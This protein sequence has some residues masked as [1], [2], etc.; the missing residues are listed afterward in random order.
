MSQ[1][2]GGVLPYG[3][4]GCVEIHHP[5]LHE[6]RGWYGQTGSLWE[7]E[8]PE[9]EQLEE[10][11]VEQDVSVVKLHTQDPIAFSSVELNNKNGE[12]VSFLLIDGSAPSSDFE[13]KVNN[14]NVNEK[15]FSIEENEENAENAE[16]EI[17]KTESEERKEPNVDA[18]GPRAVYAIGAGAVIDDESD[19]ED[20]IYEDANYYDSDS[21][22]ISNAH[23]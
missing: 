17:V 19:S 21:N 14:E 4:N 3:K 10:T 11:M 7:D 2:P 6:Q 20:D 18:V 16:N 13:K 1:K 15:C 5:L 23:D 8:E 9:E 12:I 22:Y